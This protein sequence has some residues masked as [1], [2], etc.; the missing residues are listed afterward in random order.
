MKKTGLVK[1]LSAPGRGA[2][3]EAQ[4]MVRSLGTVLEPRERY[5]QATLVRE[6]LLALAEQAHEVRVEAVLH[7]NEV[8]RWPYSDIARELGLTKPTVQS[9]VARARKM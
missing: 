4:E 7:L 5:R 2:L 1:R 3:G 6:T 8:D 9:M